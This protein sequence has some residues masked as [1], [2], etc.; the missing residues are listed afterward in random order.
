MIDNE[1]DKARPWEAVPEWLPRTD[2]LMVGTTTRSSL[3]TRCG[4]NFRILS[5]TILS[6]FMLRW[7]NDLVIPKQPSECCNELSKKDQI[8]FL[9]TIAG[10]Q[11]CRSRAMGR[12]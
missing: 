9:A 2:F 3:L 1:D 7:R 5:H 6:I 8:V 4:R 10:F 11:S 12:G